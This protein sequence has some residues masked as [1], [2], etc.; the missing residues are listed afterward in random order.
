[1]LAVTDSLAGGALVRNTK[2]GSSPETTSMAYDALREDWDLINTV[3]NGTGAMRKAGTKYT[4]KFPLES[5]E[6][7][8]ARLNKTV[9]LNVLKEAI[10]GIASRPFSRLMTLQFTDENAD[11]EEEARRA[12]IY[13][14]IADVDRNGTSL[15]AYMLKS[16]RL[17]T[18]SLYCYTLVDY[19][20]KETDDILTLQEEYELGYRPYFTLIEAEQML[21][22]RKKTVNGK[23]GVVYARWLSEEIVPHGE[24][25]EKKIKVVHELTA[26][27]T[28]Q[29][30]NG[31][32]VYQPATWRTH[33]KAP[34]G[35]WEVEAREVDMGASHSETLPIHILKI[36]D[37]DRPYFI[38]LAYKNVEHWN[39]A[40][41][42]RNNLTHARFPQR[43]GIGLEQPVDENGKPTTIPAGAEQIYYLPI[44]GDMKYIQAPMGGIEAGAKDLE[45]LAKEMYRMS[46]APL[47]AV[48][49][50]TATATV[51]ASVQVNSLLLEWTQMV[52]EFAE[53]C[54]AEMC[55]WY[56]MRDDGFEV[57]INTKFGLSKEEME[58]LR[59]FKDMQMRGLITPGIYLQAFQDRVPVPK[60]WDLQEQIDYAT[61][62]M[63]SMMGGF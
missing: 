52:K 2:D 7:Y 62:N 11:K 19:P 1:M 18:K 27:Q 12:L 20:R 55:R 22:I 49:G 4:P 17:A 34:N 41:D 40:S 35:Q 61:Q 43:V 14:W 15:H 47:A 6:N 39:S 42:Q 13:E 60:N 21:A 38:D 37:G 48:P 25:G 31:E 23:T 8:E 50:V 3:F 5:R 51:T 9:L 63:E 44:D 24:F 32:W 56:E 36:G 57:V 54:I 53:N 26:G 10:Y 29:D 16:M 59:E 45:T 33:R 58:E 28:V 46:L 30:A